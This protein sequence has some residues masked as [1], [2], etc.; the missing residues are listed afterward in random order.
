MF[1][2]SLTFTLILRVSAQ[3]NALT[4]TLSF[5]KIVANVF[6]VSILFVCTFNKFIIVCIFE[7]ILV[8]ENMI[9]IKNDQ[10][11]NVLYFKISFCSPESR[12]MFCMRRLRTS[13]VTFKWLKIPNNKYIKT[14]SHNVNVQCLSMFDWLFVN[15]K[16]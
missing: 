14:E 3:S 8:C 6:W 12:E 11:K 7:M 1:V 5:S 9:V 15:L 13:K 4:V 2:S 10:N 16:S